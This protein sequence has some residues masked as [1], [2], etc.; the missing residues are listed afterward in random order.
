M[1][2]RAFLVRGLLAGLLAGLAAFTV[3]YTLGEPHVDRA[4]SLEQAGTE[5]QE[6]ASDAGA[7]PS[8]DA[9]NTAVS[10]PTQ[11]TWGLLTGTLAVGVGLGGVVSLAAAASAGRVGRLGVTAS[12]AL[13]TTVGFVTVALV[14]F[15]KYPANPPAVG[16]A[17]TLGSRTTLYFGFLLVS[18]LAGVLAVVGA[19]RLARRTGTY[20]AVVTGTVGYLAVVGTAGLLF[21]TVNEVGD[22]PGDTLWY[23]RRASL[24]T[25]A[26]MWVVIGV[27]LSGLLLR[28]QADQ[29]RS[30]TVQQMQPVH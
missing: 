14:P 10:R 20:P 5:A 16:T 7:A 3:A 22:F 9:D 28:L 12:T 6:P 15:L 1:T 2:A 4:I 21:P 25:V 8:G 13:V 24:L 27:V 29:T 19:T 30:A 23:F 18:L 26:A 11:R 17:E